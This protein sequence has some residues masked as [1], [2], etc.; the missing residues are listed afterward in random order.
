MDIDG[1]V[2]KINALS[3]N[4][5]KSRETALQNDPA[6]R[7]KELR[8]L[9]STER[10]EYLA[11]IN[12]PETKM[13]DGSDAQYLTMVSDTIKICQASVRFEMAIFE[14]VFLLPESKTD[15]SQYEEYKMELKGR[16]VGLEEISYNYG[17]LNKSFNL[18]LYK[19]IS[20]IKNIDFSLK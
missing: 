5:E 11:L 12:R 2:A 20:C 18:S 17:Y 19:L 4:I 15:P 16:L 1:W 13:L 7:I 10:T 3:D 8:A 9:I 14:L 6:D